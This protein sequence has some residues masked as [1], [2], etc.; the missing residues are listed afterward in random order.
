MDFKVSRAICS[1]IIIRSLISCSFIYLSCT[2]PK[3]GC[4]SIYLLKGD[5]LKTWDY[6]NWYFRIGLAHSN[7][8]FYIIMTATSSSTQKLWDVSLNRLHTGHCRNQGEEVIIFLPL[9]DLELPMSYIICHPA[10]R[11]DT[12]LNLKWR[13]LNC[14]QACH[15]SLSELHSLYNKVYLSFIRILYLCVT[16]QQPSSTK[17]KDFSVSKQ[18]QPHDK[19]W[20]NVLPQWLN[21]IT[22]LFSN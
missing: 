7:D 4:Q 13:S 21:N 1:K 15:R 8:N 3:I 19:Q 14:C 6:Y 11:V 12:C 9:D 5:P 2:S 17:I 10:E 22:K 16:R 20:D 18:G